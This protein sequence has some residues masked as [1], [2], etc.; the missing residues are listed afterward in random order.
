MSY[1][2]KKGSFIVLKLTAFSLMIFL[3]F[4]IDIVNEVNG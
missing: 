4:D 2:A 3:E 1:Y